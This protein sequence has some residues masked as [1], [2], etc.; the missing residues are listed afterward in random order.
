MIGISILADDPYGI[1][2]SRGI[3]PLS[4]FVKHAERVVLGGRGI[5]R[6]E[7]AQRLLGGFSLGLRFRLETLRDLVIDVADEH[8]LHHD[9]LCYHHDSIG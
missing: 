8:L 5:L 4:D 3:G 1:E 2:G 7:I 6:N 9:I